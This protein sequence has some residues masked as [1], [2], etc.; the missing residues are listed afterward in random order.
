MKNRYQSKSNSA[1]THFQNLLLTNRIGR[2]T[3]FVVLALAAA[4]ITVSTL[5]FAQSQ[6][7]VVRTDSGPKPA[8]TTTVPGKNG[9][10]RANLKR[11]KR[12]TARLAQQDQDETGN[13]QGR[14]IRNRRRGE[15]TPREWKLKKA[16]TFDGDLRQLP[17]ERPVKVERPEREGPVPNPSLFVPPGKAAPEEPGGPQAPIGGPNAPAPPPSS[18]FEGLF[19]SANG[20]GHPPDTVGDVGPN[21]YIQAINTSIGIYDK[22]GNQ[23]SAFT[24]NTFMSQGAFGNLCDTNN[25]GD[26]VVLYDTFEDRWVVT[27]FAFQLSG[28]SVVA[29][30]GAF[31]CFAV[32]K[33]GDP[34]LGGW[35]Y[36]SLQITDLLNDYPKFG[37]WPD[38]IYMSA[39]MFGFPAGSP[40]AG[41]RVWALN[42]AQMYAGAPAIQVLSFNVPG[43]DFT[44]IPSNARLQTGTP[45]PG[46]PN[47]FLS[48]WQF[49][50]AVTVYK[51]HVDWNNPSA[52]TFT[53]PDIPIAATGWPNAAV[54]NAPSQGGNS[55][56]VLQIRAMMQN[57]Y[58]NIGGVESL[59]ATHTVRRANT[60][61]FAAPRFYQVPVTGGTV[62][63]NITQAATFDPDAAN[64]IHRFMP[65]LAIDRAGNMALGYSTSSSTTKPAIKYAGRLSTDPINTFSQ[66]EQLLIQGAGTQTGNC[67]PGVCTRWGDYSAMT[68]DPDGCTFWYTNMYYPVDGLDH[69]TRIGSFSLPQCTTIGTGSVQ[70][71]VTSSSG[72]GPISGATVALG[73]RIATT[74]AAGYY[75]FTN[76]PAGTYPYITATYPGYTSATVISLAVNE[77]SVTTQ[78]FVL[79]PGE[80]IGCFTDTT[81]ADFQNGAPSNVDLTTSPGDVLLAKPNIDQQNLTVSTSGF[82]F[83]NVAWV[84]QTFTPAVT[85]QLT[86]VDLDLFCASCSGANPN[87]TVSIRN[88]TG[89]VPSGADLATATI[90]GFNSPSGGF[91]AANFGA[92]PTLTAGTRYAIVFRLVAARIGTQ[93]YVTSTA[94]GQG[95]YANGRRATSANSGGTWTGDST[96][97][98]GFITYMNSGYAASGTLASSTKDAN[99]YT[100]GTVSWTTISW[101]AA[102]PANTSVKFQVA[103]SN[104]PI[105]PFNFVGPNGTAAT[106]FTTSGASLSQFNGLRYLK[107]K[108]FL[109][110]TDSNVTP[111]L[112]DVTVC[113][114][115][116]VPTTLTVNSASGPFG[117]TVNL[118]AK[119]TDGV[120]PLSGKTIDFSLNGNGAGNAVTNGSGVASL[121]NVSLTGINAGVYPTGVGA[122]FAGDPPYLGSN[123]TNSL[124]VG[125]VNPVFGNLSSPTIECTTASVNLSGSISFSGLIPTG[126]VAITLNAV[127]QNA[128]IQPDGSFSSTFATGSLTPAGSPYPITYFY[129]G[130]V[131]FGSANGGGT[132][133]VV[134]TTL[135]T[136]TLNGNSIALWPPNKTYRT[137]NVTDFVVSASDGCDSSL[138]INNV[139]ISKV[140]SDE[141]TSSSGD[142][143]IA[144]N[145]KSVQL[146]QDRNGNGDGRVYTITFRVRD[147]SG[148]TTTA[149]AK[150]TVPH[151]QGQGINAVD[152]GIAYTINSGC[153]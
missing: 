149:S 91:F 83:S 116:T 75:S 110:T 11:L 69:H 59:W 26:P 120:S 5:S 145:C 51:F 85:G 111:T 94:G 119:L 148:N 48:T 16:R 90:P 71:N 6:K 65:S 31:Q 103:A 63:P 143:I 89:D 1:R 43:S 73:S 76:L 58:S 45:P 140:T 35:N 4:A 118:S 12:D 125:Q 152:S 126:D 115:N 68:L 128:A 98:L 74:D 10:A 86:R 60:A 96:R 122:S 44:V 55:L 34:V 14:G 25:F 105:G 153:P 24:F 33:T 3:A 47:Y 13:R 121:S 84:A 15:N 147:A 49:L 29:P 8:S 61:G 67:G 80:A 101:N 146:R 79:S 112:N 81:Q 77:A 95:P 9:P 114:S 107:Y 124:S 27:D 17:R 37:I 108:A 97:D 129:P 53:G 139:V 20:N 41:A 70:G 144:A 141:G 50:N 132:L 46:T 54:A 32:S 113:H 137:I 36:Y 92:P 104:S 78:N 38:G 106:F 100:G 64:V 21:H 66:T 56:D 99:P 135:P 82:G 7:R 30:P 117:G 62:G 150:V 42:K 88:T 102:T 123:A 134:D 72:G 23:I 18:T 19:F 142:I 40:F 39:N 131:N 28:G 127:T 93:A 22:A 151:D 109:G 133:T 136:I 2:L 130:D 57:Q 87:I 52:S 138:N